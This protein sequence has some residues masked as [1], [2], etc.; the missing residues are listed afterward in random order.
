MKHNLLISFNLIDFVQISNIINHESWFISHYNALFYNTLDANK[1]NL[2]KFNYL[3]S[4][5]QV[6]LGFLS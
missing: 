4:K 3:N 5:I 1:T 6:P 2:M